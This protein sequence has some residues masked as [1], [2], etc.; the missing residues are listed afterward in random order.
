MID[1]R[2]SEEG[3]RASDGGGDGL[4][5]GA[6]AG[7]PVTFL[8]FRDQITNSY[9]QMFGTVAPGKAVGALP[10]RLADGRGAKAA[11][12]VVVRWRAVS[13]L[14]AKRQPVLEVGRAREIDRAGG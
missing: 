9:R 2:S 14:V 11:I 5:S 6:G 1:E 7:T 13:R 8:P 12:A 10:W 4:E 3:F